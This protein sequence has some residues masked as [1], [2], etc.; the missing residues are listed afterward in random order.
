M[1]NFIDALESIAKIALRHESWH[2]GPSILNYTEKGIDINATTARP[3]M[4]WELRSIIDTSTLCAV[5]SKIWCVY[6][7]ICTHITPKV[8]LPLEDLRRLNLLQPI[9]APTDQHN[10]TNHHLLTRAP[11]TPT[12]TYQQH[13]QVPTNTNQHLTNQHQP[14]PTNTNQRAP[15]NNARHSGPTLPITRLTSL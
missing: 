11:I 14:T 4:C 15:G 13:Q 8:R 10:S 9:P 12:S 1:Y 6:M 7:Y 2:I 3:F 5:G